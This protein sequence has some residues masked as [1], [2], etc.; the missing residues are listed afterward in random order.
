MKDLKKSCPDMKKMRFN[1]TTLIV[2]VILLVCYILYQHFYAGSVNLEL[3]INSGNNK[4]VQSGDNQNAEYIMYGIDTCGWTVKQKDELG[5][6][7]NRVKYVN[8]ETDPDTCRNKN[9]KGYP[10]WEIK[11][12]MSSG[13]RTKEEVFGE[14]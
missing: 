8:C 13:F 2:L 6:E 4:M 11:G 3:N 5:Y 7:M 12:E 10:T 14:S 1:K 9:I